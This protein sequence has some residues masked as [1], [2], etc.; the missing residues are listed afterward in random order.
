[1]TK[2]P[3][4]MAASA[5]A[6]LLR[7]AHEHEEDFN[8]VLQRYAA[9]RFLY[10][11]G[12]SAERSHFVLKGAMLF[13]LWGG[14]LYRATRDV[15]LTGYGPGEGAALDR[16]IKTICATACPPDGIEFLT[17]KVQI[18]PI[19]DHTEDVGFRVR[20]QAR[21]DGARI[22]LQIDIGYGDAIVPEAIDSHYPT[23]LIGAPVPRIRVYS[24]ETVIAEKLHA[25]ISL[26]EA[27]TR[28]KDF[29]DLFML[30]EHFSFS[31]NTLC[32]SVQHTFER[33]RTMLPQSAPRPM[34]T[35][36]YADE[37]R[38]LQWRR[39][40]DKNGLLGAARDFADVGERLRVFFDPVWDSVHSMTIVSTWP[41]R[42]PWR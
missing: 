24:R 41:P 4:N 8:L 34:T 28:F 13:A 26:D 33:R 29:Y 21:L 3:T 23:L 31:L 10:R 38:A 40:L 15:D 20:L 22:R 7:R 27:N 32:S 42:G 36:F 5:R 9:E 39:H 16:A 2:P 6:R 17:G 1:M 12:A 37:T 19:R 35:A 30:S 14:S 11:L 18:E 25:M